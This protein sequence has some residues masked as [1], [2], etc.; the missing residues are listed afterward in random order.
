MGL[1]TG[2]ALAAQYLSGMYFGVFLA[3]FM[4]VIWGV[5]AIARKLRGVA[6]RAA[7]GGGRTGWRA[8][9]AHAPSVHARAFLDRRAKQG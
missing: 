1:L 3:C 9:P 7:A 2:A 6:I 5:L 4:F 8:H